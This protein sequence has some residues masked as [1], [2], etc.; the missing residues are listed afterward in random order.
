MRYLD[1]A[2]GL[3]GRSGCGAG[4]RNEVPPNVSLANLVLVNDPL[5][6]HGGAGDRIRGNFSYLPGHDAPRAHVPCVDA[7]RSRPRPR[8]RD[9]LSRT[10]RPLPTLSLCPPLRP[11]PAC[12]GPTV[13]AEV[14]EGPARACLG[15]ESAYL[16]AALYRTLPPASA[17]RVIWLAGREG[18]IPV[19]QLAEPALRSAATPSTWRRT[20]CAASRSLPAM[21]GPRLVRN[22]Q[23]LCRAAALPGWRRP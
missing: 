3:T 4:C 18:M 12:S 22:D 5:V 1:T 17:L 9:A 20:A 15:P 19:V 10:L 14:W 2:I 8:R 13:S 16:R 6:I 11:A 23:P 7:L 21:D